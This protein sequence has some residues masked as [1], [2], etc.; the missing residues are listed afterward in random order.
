[1]EEVIKGGI[2]GQYNKLF[3]LPNIYM[4]ASVIVIGFNVF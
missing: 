3:H 1:M 4:N 2:I